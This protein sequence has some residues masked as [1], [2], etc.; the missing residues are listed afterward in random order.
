MTR[1]GIGHGNG[2]DSLL[3]GRQVAES[4]ARSGG[5]S[6]A[7]LII[8]FCSGLLD[9]E[10]FFAGIREAAGREAPVIGGSAIG[11]IT[12]DYLSYRGFPAAVAMVQS[13]GVGFATASAGDI[14]K[15]EEAAGGLLAERLPRGGSDRLLLTFYDSVRVPPG[16]PGPPVL[17]SS[18]PLLLGMER[19]LAG[20][21][22]IFGA[23]LV[24]D[25]GFNPTRQFCGSTVETRHVVGCMMSGVFS[26]Y[27]SIMHGCVPLDGI[28]HRITT[29]EGQIIYELDG[30]PVVTLIDRIF[31]N[32]QWQEERPVVNCLTIG[33]NYGERFGVPREGDYVNRLI[34]GVT[35]DRKGIAMFEPDLAVG[36]E[37]Q[38][39]VRDNRMMHQSVRDDTAELLGRIAAD[40][41]RPFFGIYI[42]CAGRTAEQSFSA[43]EEAAEVQRQLCASSVPLFG[44][45]SGV[46]IAPLLGR[47]RGLDW[48]GVLLILTEER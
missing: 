42:D 28:Y 11:V 1:V 10:A 41:R 22:P 48:T 21:I 20:S 26:F 4:A 3:L 5:I 25:Y 37:V 43:E 23:G 46:E 39:M 29:M 34:T 33:V 13:D 16:N 6:H 19:K 24:G 7:D 30:I 31:G 47:S 2:K 36:M 14:L 32:A 8:A 12:N 18:A 38:F 17:N 45:Y 35:P 44:F 27:H 9:H 15:G 40:G